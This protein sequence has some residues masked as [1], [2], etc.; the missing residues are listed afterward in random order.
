[1]CIRDSPRIQSRHTHGTGCTLASAVAAGMASGT[2]LDQAVLSARD[3]V[4]EAIRTAPGIGQG[5]GPL[6]HGL[7]LKDDVDESAKT[8]NA[9]PFANLKDMMS[10]KD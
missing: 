9:N 2:P 8:A 4:Y 6:N 10:P 3:F 7:L 5:H 1:M